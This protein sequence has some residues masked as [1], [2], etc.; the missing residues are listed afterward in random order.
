MAGHLAFHVPVPHHSQP[1]TTLI[2]TLPKIVF[3]IS[4]L[5]GPVQWPGTKLQVD[6]SVGTNQRHA[7]ASKI[8]EK[9]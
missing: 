2:T 5:P 8:F 9:C 1:C 7:K 6:V 4:G 3:E